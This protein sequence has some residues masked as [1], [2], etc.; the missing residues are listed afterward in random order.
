MRIIKE[1]SLNNSRANISV[2]YGFDGDHFTVTANIWEVGKKRTEKNFIGG[3][4]C[5]DDVLEN[6]PELKMFVSLHLCD[7]YGRPLHWQENGFYHL[8]RMEREKF[9]SYYNILPEQYE[10]ICISEDEQHFAAKVYFAGIFGSWFHAANRAFFELGVSG[11]ESLVYPEVITS[12]LLDDIAAKVNVGY[13]TKEAI[14]ERH[15]EKKR[16]AI[17]ERHEKIVSDYNKKVAAARAERDVS[18]HVLH[19]FG[20]PTK[21][22]FCYYSHSHTLGFNAFNKGIFGDDF[23]PDEIEAIRQKMAL[24]M[25]D[26]KVLVKKR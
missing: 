5:H 17:E 22:N 18:L 1:K 2:K 8:K 15:E 21:R 24:V 26:L 9:C 25:P 4:C 14:E 23:T 3:G 20:D 7:K 11:P 16:S 10:E 19:L 6:F 12:E 13:Y